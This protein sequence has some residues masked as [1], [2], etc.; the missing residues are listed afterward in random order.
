MRRATTKSIRRRAPD[1]KPAISH[2]L[3]TPLVAWFRAWARDLPWRAADPALGPPYRDPYRSLVSEF[4]LQQ[5]Q[6]SR[7]EPKFGAFL[8]RF[9]NVAAL[10]KASEQDVLSRVGGAWV[11]PAGAPAPC[12]GQ[13]GHG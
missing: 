2:E 13:A 9:P 5:T 10:A 4:M 7:V 12:G 11:L 8:E 6:V 1:T 3:V